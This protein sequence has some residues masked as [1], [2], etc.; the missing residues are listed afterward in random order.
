[1]I[2]ILLAEDNIGDVMLVKE[3]LAAHH[4]E[5]ELHVVEDGQKALDFVATMGEPECS[6]C[7]DLMLL[8]MNLPKADGATVLAAFRKHHACNLTPV[9]IVTSSDTAKDRQNV[10]TLGISHYFRKPSDFDEFMELGAIIR[11]VLESRR[12]LR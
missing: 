2:H 10:S 4:I 6:P 7:P 12:E 9:I 1:M 8:D 11:E 5:S 3:A